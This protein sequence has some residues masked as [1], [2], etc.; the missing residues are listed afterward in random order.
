MSAPDP[1]AA[2]LEAIAVMIARR[3]VEELRPLLAAVAAPVS[4]TPSPLVTKQACAAG[5]GVSPA[6]LDRYVRAG[7]VPFVT[8]GPDGPRRFRLEDVLAALATR[9]ARTKTAPARREQ[10]AGVR[11]LSRESR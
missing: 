3:I 1:F 10:I 6:T 11:L 8:L 2:A 5:L 4:P 7:L 9:E